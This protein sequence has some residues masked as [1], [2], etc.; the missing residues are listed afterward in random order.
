MWHG[1]NHTHW[2]KRNLS[3]LSIH[4]HLCELTYSVV[5]IKV[6]PKHEGCVYHMEQQLCVAANVLVPLMLFVQCRSLSY[7]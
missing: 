1:V 2:R 3:I 4:L 5:S 6:P 7:D